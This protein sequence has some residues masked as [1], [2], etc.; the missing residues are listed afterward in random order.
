MKE[1]LAAAGYTGYVDINCMSNSRG[2]YPL[3]FNLPV[4][5]PARQSSESKGL[6]KWASSCR[7]GGGEPFNLRTKRGFQ[8]AS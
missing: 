5:L 8:S 1:R 4:R 2:I 7:P 3:E 6:S